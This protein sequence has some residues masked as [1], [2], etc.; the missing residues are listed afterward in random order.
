MT[1]YWNHLSI[2]NEWGPIEDG[3]PITMPLTWHRGFPPLR[4]P[5]DPR[6]KGRSSHVLAA[7]SGPR[8]GSLGDRQVWTGQLDY[9]RISQYPFLLTYDT[10]HTREP[11]AYM[12]IAADG[13]ILNRD[14]A[15]I[16]MRFR[17]SGQR[18]MAPNENSRQ[19]LCRRL[20]LSPWIW[21]HTHWAVH[22][23]DLYRLLWEMTPDIGRT[24]PSESS[25]G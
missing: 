16:S 5:D 22:E 21:H 13:E 9:Q 18:F 7:V 6:N 10:G 20:G 19:K 2:P 12:A 3:Q 15:S 17:F 23:G 11:I 8:V 24:F 4:M 1:Q 14:A 25:L